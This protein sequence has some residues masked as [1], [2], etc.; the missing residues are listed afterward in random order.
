ML[1]CLIFYTEKRVYVEFQLSTRYENIEKNDSCCRWWWW[2]GGLSCINNTVN[3]ELDLN[4]DILFSL[5]LSAQNPFI[6][7]SM[8]PEIQKDLT[9]RSKESPTSPGGHW[10]KHVQTFLALLHEIIEVK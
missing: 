4:N 9:R 7:K 5:N 1:P 6:T 10:G 3:N 8:L 2:V